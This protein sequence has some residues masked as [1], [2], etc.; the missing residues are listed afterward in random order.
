LCLYNLHSF[1]TF[2]K[3]FQYLYAQCPKLHSTISLHLFLPL[4]VPWV[5]HGAKYSTSWIHYFLQKQYHNWRGFSSKF[6]LRVY[7]AFH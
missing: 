7:L 5:L 4:K 3:L 1:H 2:Y 6:L